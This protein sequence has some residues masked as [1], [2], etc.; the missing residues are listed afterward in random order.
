MILSEVR[1]YVRERGQASLS[2][3]ALHFSAEPDAVR[4]MLEVWVR[5]GKVSKRMIAAA[6]G[7]S[8]HQCASAATEVYIWDTE[9][10]GIHNCPLSVPK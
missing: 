10:P 9:K 4:G 6:C 5:K 8:C 3:I 7:T 2:D 1:D